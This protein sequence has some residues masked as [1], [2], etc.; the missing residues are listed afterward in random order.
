MTIEEVRAEFARIVEPLIRERLEGKA[1]PASGGGVKG[2]KDPDEAEQEP[3][4]D[5]LRSGE[6]PKK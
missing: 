1:K 2:P 6:N 3:P 5:K 4:Q